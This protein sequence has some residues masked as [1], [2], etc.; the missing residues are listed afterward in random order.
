MEVDKVFIK[1]FKTLP[2]AFPKLQVLELGGD[3]VST[4][5]LR[6]LHLLARISTLRYLKINNKEPITEAG[7]RLTLLK[8]A[9]SSQ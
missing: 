3:T 9:D 4:S 8:W 2:A 7:L 6:H 5:D 1:M